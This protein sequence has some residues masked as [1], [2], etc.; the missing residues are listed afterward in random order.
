MKK[1]KSEDLI[2]QLEKD[3]RQIIAAADHLKQA[4]PV[5]LSYPPAEGKWS[6][7]QVLEHLNMYNRYYLPQIERS[8]VHITRDTNAWFISGFFGNYFTNMMA[9]KNV[10][11]VKNKMKAMRDYTPTKGINVEAVFNE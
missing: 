2:D 5:K 3:V 9:P 11:E 4:D 8:M 10:F 6:V 1:F 7:A